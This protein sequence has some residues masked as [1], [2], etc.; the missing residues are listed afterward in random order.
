MPQAQPA[1][2]GTYSQF[3]RFACPTTP[4]NPSV[5]PLSGKFTMCP[6]G[7]RQR[8]CSNMSE[9]TCGFKYKGLPQNY[10]N[11][12]MACADET[13]FGYIVGNCS[14]VV[15]TCPATRFN[16]QLTKI[17]YI[18]SC[19]FENGKTPYNVSNNLCCQNSTYSQVITGEC[20]AI[21]K[22]T[23]STTC[24]AKQSSFCPE[25]YKP[26]CGLLKDSSHKTYPNSCVACADK[27]VKSYADGQC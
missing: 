4:V 21:K 2:S 18:Y 22:P 25:I 19:A 5:D 14:D 16:C 8:R 6:E 13:V 10:G 3:L 12:C 1:A 27:R 11:T 7:P 26:V 20:P 9:R 24:P 15:K 23:G 17:V